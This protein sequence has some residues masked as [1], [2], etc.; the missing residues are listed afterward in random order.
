MRIFAVILVCSVVVGAIYII[1]FLRSPYPYDEDY[2]VCYA[3][4]PE[5]RKAGISVK[6]NKKGH[7]EIALKGEVDQTN[8]PSESHLKLFLECVIRIAKQ[9]GKKIKLV[10]IVRLPQ[11][12]LGQVR[13]RWS[14][15]KDIPKLA[16]TRSNDR[17]NLI[18]IGDAVGTKAGVIRRWCNENASCVQ[19]EPEKPNENTETVTIS[20]KPNA[21]LER[22]EMP[23]TTGDPW[24]VPPKGHDGKPIAEPWQDIDDNGTRYFLVCKAT[25]SRGE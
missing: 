23:S 16:W 25:S 9:K 22:Q 1:I 7:I 14:R 4:L 3:L 6:G 15:E 19:C 8:T 5:K 2:A 17:L 11:E 21:Q 18:R 12:P 24:P 20:L 13:N 10:N